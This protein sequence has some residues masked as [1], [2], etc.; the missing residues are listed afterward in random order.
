MYVCMYVCMYIYIY[1]CIYTYIYI[2]IYIYISLGNPC[3]P[4]NS[5]PLNSDYARVK[6]CEI[7]NVSREIGHSRNSR[8]SR[9]SS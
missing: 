6:P 3:A 2:Y 1:I 4:G 8:N 7:H 9:S 5:T